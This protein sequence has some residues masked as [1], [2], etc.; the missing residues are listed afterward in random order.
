MMLAMREDSGI[1]ANGGRETRKGIIRLVFDGTSGPMRFEAARVEFR[2]RESRPR[3]N[4][5]M[6][7]I[8]H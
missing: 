2:V 8:A 3:R 6:P 1:K 5:R 7:A 4:D